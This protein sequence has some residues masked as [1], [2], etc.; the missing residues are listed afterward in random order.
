MI[1]A[2][3]AL[4]LV[5]SLPGRAVAGPCD[6]EAKAAVKAGRDPRLVG[7]KGT[8]AGARMDDGNTRYA[9]ALK[10]SRVVATQD[11]AA[12]EF[13]AAIEAYVAAEMQEP[14]PLGLYN[15]AQ[16]YRAMGDYTR[17]I[18]QYRK[19][20]ET[21]KPGRPLRRL[22]ECHITS[23]SAELERAASK[24]PPTGPEPTKATPP[25]RTPAS[26]T[27]VPAAL[28]F[29]DG[30][31]PPQPP[32]SLDGRIPVGTMRESWQADTVGW[33]IGGAGLAITAVGGYLLLDA[34]SLRADADD[35]PRED[36]RIDLRERADGRGTW[37]TVA[38]ISG[39]LILTAGIV[40]LALRPDAPRHGA[41][42]ASL[43][44]T[45]NG[46]A[47]AGHF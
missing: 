24:A 28:T 27:S 12:P 22:V 34:R 38:A 33:T 4:V 42:G 40:K 29:P 15:L 5:S 7:P 16:T 1:R 25:E 44:F 6:A 17:A 19:F 39:G 18:A 46:L 36:L 3:L 47:L 45:T 13:L 9:E 11:T 14:S 37:G 10:R 35:E 31:L 32:A 43:R 20:L 30:A 23:M 2:L 21:A 8:E 26:T 41:S